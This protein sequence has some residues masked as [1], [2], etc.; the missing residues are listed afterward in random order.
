MAK[1]DADR[2]LLFGLLALQTGLINQSALL[3]AFHTW[4]QAKNRHLAE[5]LVEQGALD[6][7]GQELIEALAAKHLKL[8]GGDAQRSLAAVPTGRATLDGLARLA[9]PAI[10]ASL[11]GLGFGSTEPG[12]VDQTA[13]YSVG[14]ATS[15]GQ[16]FRILRPHAQGGLGAVYVALDG[17]LNREVALKQILDH[18]ADDPTSRTRFLI[19][20]EITGGLEHPGIVPVYGLG[21][22]ADGRPFYAMRFIR[23]ES[24]KTA[25]A[26]FHA[27]EPLRRDPGRRSLALRKLLRRFIDIC[28]AIEYAHSR[29]ILHRDIKPSNVIVGKHGETLIV[30]WGLAKPL[31]H[32]EPA[33]PSDERTLIP[34]SASRSAETLPGSALGTPAYMSPE[35]AAGA[36]DRLGPWSDVY[37]LGATLYGL[38]T[39]QPPFSGD[40]VGAVLQAVQ[41]GEFPPPRRLEPSLGQPLEA[42]CMKAMALGPEDRYA[43]PRALADDLQRRMADEPVTALRDPLA[44]QA[45]L[46]MR[47]HRPVVAAASALLVTAV[48]AL[49]AGTLLLRAANGQIR[50]QRD[51]AR[52]QRE[53][54]QVGFRQ[55]RQ[56]VDDYFT[57]ISEN[58]LLSSPVPGM[59]PLRKE[60]LEMAL[61]YYRSFQ[62]Q[63][64]D[65][66]VLRAEVAPAIERVGRINEA[67]G[68]NEET[69]ADH[70]EAMALFGSLARD[71]PADLELRQDLARV[72]RSI[73]SLLASKMGHP[74]EGIERLRNAVALSASLV[75]EE[76]AR[77][78]FQE[79]LASCYFGLGYALSYRTETEGDLPSLQEALAIWDRLARGEPRY[80]LQQA[81]TLG[82][83]G[84][85]HC[86][87]GSADEAL[88]S[89]DRARELLEQLRRETPGE[90][91]VARYL[92]EV[93]KQIGYVHTSLTH[94]TE[95]ALNAFRQSGE[96]WDRLAIENPAVVEFRWFRVAVSCWLGATLTEAGR[97]AEAVNV[98][99]E[100]I[101]E[102]ERMVATAPTDLNWRVQLA[103]ALITLGKAFSHQGRPADAVAPLMKSL[104]LMEGLR[105]ADPDN[106]LC[107]VQQARC[108]RFLGGVLH[109]LRRDDEA[110]RALSGAVR[111]LEETSEDARHQNNFIISNLAV[112]Y[113]DLGELQHGTG[114]LT[115]A[116]GTLEK[117]DALGLV[118]TGQAGSP[119]IDPAWL[120]DSRISLG[121]VRMEMGKRDGAREPLL[122]AE[123]TLRELPALDP[124]VI[125]SLAAADSAL[126]ELADTEAERKA[127]DEKAAAA[128]RRAVA[129]VEPKDLGEMATSPAF[130]RLRSRP[131]AGVLLFDRI[132]P[133][134]PFAPAE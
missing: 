126:A 30:D 72:N 96:I 125:P 111:L 65:D 53:L 63:A 44:E 110:I 82:R 95:K 58:T 115:D 26:A 118:Y 34:S 24:L 83:I 48:V 92:A 52:K 123:A 16:R 12:D 15:D 13:S 124:G 62:A 89:L 55:A 40:D 67:I 133:A 19:E 32:S 74:D 93:W 28:N 121:L 2:N 18:H 116:Q 11:A 45:R 64:R 6:G 5:I 17:E 29:G 98:L 66:P 107:L 21:T 132:F 103:D 130:R 37:S 128:F 75:R 57:R 8:N 38:L 131:V 42:I 73:G 54:A 68:T 122:R 69:L 41:K 23:G 86:R 79:E 27:D 117:A 90:I 88:V 7:D 36:L 59:Q 81:R 56:A 129:V 78:E 60:Q 51:E 71:H 31:G 134:T 10:D 25:I 33:G 4:T 49:G 43:S 35:Q 114:R 39:G 22:Y 1:A 101:A 100:A 127:Y 97:S 50:E 119:L 113:G 77:L 87:S 20:A 61:R 46:W 104:A 120:M 9:D 112:I 102:G 3:V 76:P 108:I 99:Q 109:T 85:C 47:R 14:A 94:R 84:F 80:R 106:S 105:N 70:E 91:G